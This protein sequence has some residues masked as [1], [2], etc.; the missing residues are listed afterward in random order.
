MSQRI[1]G[2]QQKPG[3]FCVEGQA[4]RLVEE[5]E[6]KSFDLPDA[7]PTMLRPLPRAALNEA[8]NPFVWSPISI[9]AMLDKFGGAESSSSGNLGDSFTVA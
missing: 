3:I 5:I 1:F 9:D 4:S 2:G 6:K 7:A 8:A